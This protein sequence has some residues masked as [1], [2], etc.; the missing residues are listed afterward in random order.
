M[1]ADKVDNF[2]ARKADECATDEP[3]AIW[4][5][6]LKLHSLKLWHQ[7]SMEV[8]AALRNAA[9][10]KTLDMGEFW[11]NVISVYKATL[12]PYTVADIA[13]FRAHDIFDK[14]G[15]VKAKA[16]LE[17]L[18]T[19]FKKDIGSVIRLKTVLIELYV[20]QGGLPKETEDVKPNDFIAEVLEQVEQCP[21]NTEALSAYYYALMKYYIM[22]CEYTQLYRAT[23]NYLDVARDITHFTPQEILSYSYHMCESAV[24]S[25]EIF[26]LGEC[27]NH[28]IHETAMKISN[29]NK[30]IL[31]FVDA[32]VQGD[33][34][35]FN[36]SGYMK[37]NTYANKHELLERKIRLCATMNFV[38]HTKS[39]HIP[40]A[41]F[42]QYCGVT[43]EQVEYLLMKAVSQ[44]LIRGKINEVDKVF[45]LEWIK[46][47]TLGKKHLVVLR[48]R[49]S[50][51]SKGVKGLKEEYKQNMGELKEISHPPGGEVCM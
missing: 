49:Y 25:D 21:G 28:P 40:Y 1:Y 10:V 33:M 7:F 37:N 3:K 5:T 19:Y 13:R 48:N 41:A 45:D 9:F 20:L 24:L 22:T 6:I 18:I 34:N 39:Y 2:L 27:Y 8:T 26:D 23:V 43:W 12:A 47:R 38:S 35:K 16:F 29:D 44:K 46:P 17:E 14:E 4:S 50:E 51:W 30:W 32:F 31:L 42:V 36:S 11:D 15:R